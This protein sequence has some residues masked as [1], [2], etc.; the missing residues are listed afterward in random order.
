MEVTGTWHQ[1]YSRTILQMHKEYNSLKILQGMKAALH[2]SFNVHHSMLVMEVKGTQ[3][4]Q[5]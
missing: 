3:I 4:H 1:T 2:E 5:G